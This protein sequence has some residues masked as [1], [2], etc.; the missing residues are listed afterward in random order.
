MQIEITTRVPPEG[1]VSCLLMEGGGRRQNRDDE[2]KKMLVDDVDA[3]LR[4]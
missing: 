2:G 1:R 4:H 3:V